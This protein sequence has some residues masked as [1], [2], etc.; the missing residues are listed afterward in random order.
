MCL[1]DICAAQIVSG[2]EMRY[3][4]EWRQVPVGLDANRW[5]TR[6]YRRIVTRLVVVHTVT[7]G[8]RLMDV[9]RL[10]GTDSRVQVVFTAAPDVFGDGVSDFLRAVGGVVVSWLQATQTRFDLALAASYG[11]TDQLHS[12]LVVLPHGAGYGKFAS[13]SPGQPGRAVTNRP[14][15]RA[16]SPASG[17]GWAGDTGGDRAAAPGGPGPDALERADPPMPQQPPSLETRATT[18]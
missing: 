12:P 18:L 9:V 2:P 8:Q 7:S 1:G 10:I 6:P 3:D 4:L 16:R 17:A 14:A 11:S 15:V 5:V 13:V